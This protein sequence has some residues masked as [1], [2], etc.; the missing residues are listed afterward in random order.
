MP[1]ELSTTAQR[2]LALGILALLLTAATAAVVV[3]LRGVFVASDERIAD[4]EFRLQRYTRQA[5]R[6]EEL[7]A[8]LESLGRQR[9]GVEELLKGA[10]SAIAG[11]NLQALLKQVVQQSGGRL[12]STQVLPELN[13]G[14]LERVSIRA[15]FSGTIE[16]L[17]R[18][19][20]G[21][22]FREPLLFVENMEARAKRMRRL[23]RNQKPADSGQT[24][25]VSLEVSG[26]RRVEVD[27]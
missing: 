7:R 6:Q 10:S 12:E 2:A 24:L 27:G 15:Q 26:F 13:Q 5:S 9:S 3:P 14:A 16:V 18:V 17:Q 23:R 1:N 8:E 19:L 22:E 4:L 11:A 25:S 21:I 20:Y